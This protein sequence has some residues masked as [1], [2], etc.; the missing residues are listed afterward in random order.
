[1]P[2]NRAMRLNIIVGGRPTVQIQAIQ[3]IATVGCVLEETL[4]VGSSVLIRF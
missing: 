4:K 2:C 1:M 3:T